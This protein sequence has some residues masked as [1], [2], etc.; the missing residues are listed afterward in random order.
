MIKWLLK[1]LSFEKIFEF[2]IEKCSNIEV[3][4]R[5]Y[6]ELMHYSANSYEEVEWLRLYLFNKRSLVL[7]GDPN[8]IKDI[9]I[10]VTNE[11]TDDWDKR[12]SEQRL[13][14]MKSDLGII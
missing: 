14:K 9:E 10:T 11:L 6:K 5:F 8:K 13:A 1:H 12:Y 3:R 2:I 4:E 7:I